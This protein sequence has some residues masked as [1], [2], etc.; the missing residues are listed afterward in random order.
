MFGEF[1]AKFSGRIL[2]SGSFGVGLELGLQVTD[3]AL[4]YKRLISMY[5]KRD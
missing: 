3:V 4:R 2:G 1:F 5:S